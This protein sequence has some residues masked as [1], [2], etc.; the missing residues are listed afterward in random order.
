MTL[1]SYSPPPKSVDQTFV[2]FIVEKVNFEMNLND[3]TNGLLNPP[4][5]IIE[6]WR[7]IFLRKRVPGVDLTPNEVIKNSKLYKLVFK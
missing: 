3:I 1:Y 7:S 6:V 2:N 5:S 4:I